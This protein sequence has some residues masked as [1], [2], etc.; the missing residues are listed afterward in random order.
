MCNLD[1]AT[2][3]VAD[4]RK[5]LSDVIT[6]S[7]SG[8]VFIERR[9]QRA[10]VVVS[11]EQ[12]VRQRSVSRIRRVRLVRKS[13]KHQQEALDFRELFGTQSARMPDDV[14]AAHSRHFVD[15]HVAVGFQSVGF[16]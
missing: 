7:K 2:L 11:S 12:C 8:E 3:S 16:L 6:R 1:I 15:H 10:A 9:G 14:G 4:A 5:H 13:E